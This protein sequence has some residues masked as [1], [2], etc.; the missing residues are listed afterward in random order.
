MERGAG[1]GHGAEWRWLSPRARD[2]QLVYRGHAAV[3][4]EKI[5]KRANVW[6]QLMPRLGGMEKVCRQSER[7]RFLV[8]IAL[9]AFRRYRLL[10]S[11]SLR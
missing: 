9:A 1:S 5:D 4:S 6:I 11:L 2:G 3:V 10:R 7:M 8:A